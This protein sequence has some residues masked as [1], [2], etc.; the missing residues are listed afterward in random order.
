MR[1]LGKAYLA[2]REYT[3][4]RECTQRAVEL[5]REAESKVQ[6]GVALRSLGEVDG[7]GGAGRRRASR[8]ASEHLKRSIAIFEEIGNEVELARSCRAYAELLRQIAGA[9]ERP[10]GRRARPASWRAEP[11]TS[12]PRC[13]R[14]SPAFPAWLSYDLR[15]ERR[16]SREGR[17]VRTG[18]DEID[19][20]FEELETLLKN[21]DVGAELA[22]RG[23][24]VSLA[25]TLADG[26]RAYLHG[27]KEKALLELGTATDEIAARLARSRGEEA[28][29]LRREARRIPAPLSGASYSAVE[30]MPGDRE[31]VLLDQRALPDRRAVRAAR[32]ASSRSPRRSRR[33]PCAARPPSG[34]RRRTA[35]CSRRGATSGGPAGVRRGDGARA[36]SGSAARARR[37]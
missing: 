21:P 28:G 10:D 30:L 1:G 4:A 29:E 8:E 20:V 7:G 9:R 6:L 25:M 18:M 2:R 35:W 19:D 5:F 26:V 14:R 27:D 11:R 3:K 33:W 37:R 15:G 22:D 13:G 32:R 16:A 36:A 31:V 17:M 23:V 12:S 24:N 34:S